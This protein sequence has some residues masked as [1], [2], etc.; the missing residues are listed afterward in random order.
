MKTNAYKRL[1]LVWLTMLLTS[2]STAKADS[3]DIFAGYDGTQNNSYFEIQDNSAYDFTNIV[4][5]ATAAGASDPTSPEYGWTSTPWSVSDVTS[6][7]ESV[8]YFSGTQAFQSDF[9]ATYAYSGVT[10]SD[11]TYVVSGDL[12]GS[13]LQLSFVGGDGAT[14]G[15]AFLG[16]DQFG[17]ATGGGATGAS[18]FGQ[19][20]T[21]P[22][23]LPSAF[24]LFA[25]SMIGLVLSR[26][27]KQLA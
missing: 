7:A 12:N 3:I 18:D 13:L 11:L 2:V 21:A 19:V 5:T 14:N 8:N 17:N 23:P 26:K 15:P 9:A 27:R 25:T 1:S 4:I 22:V 6:G 24:Y 20:A 10:P 16:L